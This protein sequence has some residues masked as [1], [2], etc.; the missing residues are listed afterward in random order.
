VGGVTTNYI[1]FFQSTNE[2]G[3]Y[4]AVATNDVNNFSTN[5]TLEGPKLKK[6]ANNWW[7]LYFINFAAH[8]QFYTDNFESDAA[9]A[10]NPSYWPNPVYS[11]T[12][13]HPNSEDWSSDIV[14]VTDA[15]T[16]KLLDGW[17]QAGVFNVFG[18]Q[19]GVITLNGQ[20][21]AI[22]GGATFPAASLLGLIP[23]SSL[24]SQ[25][26]M[27]NTVETWTGT[28]IYNMTN[29]I[30]NRASSAPATRLLGLD[31]TKRVTTNALVFSVNIA[32][33]NSPANG[34][35]LRYTNVSGVGMFYWAP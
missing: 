5:G 24:S 28:N 4:T 22:G 12:N 25:V 18:G 17:V 30:L 14:P 21:G 15:N 1:M 7:R 32:A 31:A 6:M 19:V 11:I 2:F 27:L 10:A 23:N 20:T 9:L 29:I 3:P 16:M 26:A 33:T 8:Q 13:D 34:Y 35:A